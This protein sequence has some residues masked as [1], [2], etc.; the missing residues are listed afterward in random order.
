MKL[1]LRS[2]DFTNVIRWQAMGHGRLQNGLWGVLDYLAQPALML[3]ATPLLLRRLGPSQFGLWMLA[4]AFVSSGSLVSS[5]FGDAA[6]K[7]IAGYRAHGDHRNIIRVIHAMLTINTTLSA[8]VAITLWIGIPYI[9]HHLIKVEPALR[10]VCISSFRISTIILVVKSIESIFVSTLRAFESYGPT[11]RIAIITRIA[12]LSGAIAVVVAGGNVVSIMLTTMCA[13][14]AGLLMQAFAVS[15]LLGRTLW[16]PSLHRET[17]SKIAE[18][19]CFSWMQCVASVSF[20][21]ADRLIIAV[22]LGTSTLGYYS[23]CTQIAQPVHGLLASGFQSLFPY[24]SARWE[25]TSLVSL[26]RA[27]AM[28][29]SV[30]Q[31]AVILISTPLIL[32]GKYILSLWLGATFAQQFSPTLSIVTISFALLGMNVTGYYTLLASGKVR[33]A[34]YI[35]LM[36]G[37]AMLLAM[38]ALIPRFGIAGAAAGRLIY[39]PITWLMYI[40]VYRM[41]WRPPD[42][43]LT[44]KLSLD[45]EKISI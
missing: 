26:K 18:F 22:L 16:L 11:V 40:V 23:I 4:S 37:G 38:S 9:S 17:L 35:N 5:G 45:V 19:G 15:S 32:G 25:T 2:N 44:P 3:L 13:A 14:V 41:L 27:F 29:F 12:I 20:S 30:N 8:L 6:I 28:A 7:F 39:G 34:T 10:Q 33:Q 24:L 36:A 43:T 42:E 1:G 21:Q 31:V